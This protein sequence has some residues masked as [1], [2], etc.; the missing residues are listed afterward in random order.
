MNKGDIVWRRRPPARLGCRAWCLV[1]DVWYTLEEYEEKCEEL[2]F[3]WSKSDF[4][5]LRTLHPTEGL[6]VDSSYSYE[7]LED[8]IN[9]TAGL[10]YGD[11]N[12]WQVSSSTKTG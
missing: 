5:V 10:A 8:V 7:T 6:L 3:Y 4:P 11:P 12:P 2:E 9:R 1:V